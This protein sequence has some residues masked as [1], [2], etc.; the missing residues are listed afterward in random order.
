MA[1]L[2]NGTTIAGH[3]AIHAG[4]LA[5]HSIATTTYVNT[6]IANLVNSAPAAL[7]TLNE[8]AA[9][10][11][12]D[13]S[14]ATTIN[15]SLSTKL[16]NVTGNS[17]AYDLNISGQH[18]F[19]RFS[20]GQWLNAPV[21]GNYSHVLSVNGAGDNRTVQVYLGDVPGY[22]WWRPNQGGTWHPWER[23]LTSNNFN[24]WAP[25]L[26]G[27][28]ASGTWS[29]NVTGSA[30]SVAWTNVSSRPTALSQFTNDLGNYGG[31]LTSLPSHNHDD[32][33]Y[34]ES[35][36]DGRY[37]YYRGT[38]AE[39]DFQRFQDTAGEIRFDQINDF[40]NLSNRPGGYSYGGVLSMR[41]ANF[42]FQLW[43]SHTGDFYYKTQWSDDQYS[44][45]RQVITSLNIG[46][47]SVNFA[48]S[49]SQVYHYASRTDGTWYNAVWATGNPS[50]MYSADSVQIRSSDGA[51][52]AN[53]FYDNQ[54]TA[55]YVDPASSSRLYLL[56]LGGATPDAALSV[57]GTA[58]V[59]G[60]LYLGGTAGTVNSWGTRTTGASGYW[61]NAS[62]D[63][64]FNN[65]GYGSTWTFAVSSA[66][67][68]TLNR[69]IDANTTWGSAS[70]TTIFMGWY[71]GKIMLGNN[72]D[73]AHDWANAIGGNSIISTNKHH[74]YKGAYIKNN[75]DGA[76]VLAVDGVNGRLFT[77]TDSVL[78]TIY[79]VNTIA[80]LP[81]LEITADSTV[82]I[83]KYGHITTFS[84]DG[85]VTFQNEGIR[86]PYYNG[87][88]MWFRTNTHWASISGIDVIGGAGEFR[89]SSDSGSIDLRV[90]GSFITGAG[91]TSSQWDTAF[92]KRPTGVSFSGSS[93]KTLTLTLGDGSTLTAAFNDI[94]TD[95]NT[96]NQTLS[97][98]GSTLSIS[99]G[100]SVTIPSGGMSQAT[101]DSLYVRK[102][103]WEGN[104][105][106]GT[107][108]DIYGTIF[109]DSNS[110]AYYG[111]F[112]SNSRMNNL[113][114]GSVY[115][116]TYEGQLILGHTSYN[117][118]FLNGSWSSSVRAGIL[119]NCADEWEFAIHD[120]GTSVESAFIYAGGRLLMGRNI[121]WGTMYIEAAESFRAP[122]FYDSNDTTYYGD[123]ASTSWLRHLSVGDVNAANDGGWNARLNLTG[124]SHA[125]LDVKS[126]SDGIITTIYSHTGQG[127][128]RVGTWSNHPLAFM[129]NGG[130]AGYA[131]ANYLQG[132]DSVRAPIFYD[133]NNTGYYIDPD[134]RSNIWTLTANGKDHYFGTS[135]GWDGVGFGNLTNLHFQGHNQFWIGAG[136][137]YW[138][139]GGISTEHDLLITT[140]QGYDSTSYYRGITFGVDV[141]GNGS[142]GNYRLGRWQTYNTDWKTS[143]LQV[144][145]SLAVGYGARGTRAYDE[146]QYPRDRGVWAH[147]RGEAG[148]GAD[149]WRDHL[150]S[151]TAN[152]GGPW[153]S[154]ASLEVSSIY[155]GNSDIPALFRMH[156]W[157]SGAVEF[158][159]PQGRTLYIRESPGGSGSWFNTLE[160]Q[161]TLNVTGTTYSAG[162]RGNANVGGTGEAS[163]HPAGMYSGGTEWLY[164]TMYRNGSS[165]YYAGGWNYQLGGIQLNN[166]FEIQ[167]GGADYGRF[168]SWVHL[169]GHYGLYTGINGAHFYPN[170]SSYGSWKMEGSRNGWQGIEFAS[171][172]AGNVTLM[173]H[174]DSNRSGFHNN[175]YGWQI[176]WENGTLYVGKNSY[177]G[178]DATVFDT[179]NYTNWTWAKNAWNGNIY[180]HTD[181]RI[182]G[183]IF[184]DSND[185]GYYCDPNGNSRLAD[186]HANY[187][188]SYGNARVDS[189]LYL[190]QQYG[191][192]IVG[193]YASTRL[194]GVWAM[195][196]AYKIAMDGTNA[197]NLYGLAWS[198]PNAGGQ[199]GF[200]SNHGLIMMMYGTAF[201]TLSDTI[202]C[203]GDI[204][205]F[206]DARVKT[207]IQRI[208]DPIAKVMAIRG[209]TFTRTDVEDKE[210]RHAGVI[211]QEVLEVLPEVV[212][213]NKDN[214]HYSVAYGNL[215]ALLI[216]A[217]KEQQQQIE[218]LRAEVKKLRG[219]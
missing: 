115:T 80:G 23:I 67:A 219:E 35:E 197:G 120:S 167:Q 137:A 41:G 202:W 145:A 14:F 146:A 59:D 96:D 217:I 193:V 82:R 177:G 151:P 122:I 166:G 7:D 116:P 81:I 174:T 203:R 184:Y 209:V 148:Y 149:R 142:S 161:G 157:G 175:S 91:T 85:M 150:F 3:T 1:Q 42:G 5:A 95:T 118:N 98:S 181:G 55:Y 180:I 24:S 134:G 124:S 102:N 92:N 205:A 139:R 107:G 155:E 72:N 123:F 121:G 86:I 129:V 65:E 208:E 4:N 12:N 160:V 60:T 46:S 126:N 51:I 101:A 201:A 75:V 11:G 213:Q 57:S 171:G 119:A 34:T 84:N 45:W 125:R 140:M 9:A 190:D 108:G 77:V 100:N 138:Y 156:Q 27:T 52:R 172:S 61:R 152:G 183:T 99:G 192:T 135:S 113:I 170:N 37:L 127:V 131:Y 117:F 210:K 19:F 28:G 49:S 68:V 173:I 22:L 90:D 20:Q 103:T 8:L 154:F 39:N 26:T 18:A 76:E 29:I 79:S 38:N 17:G 74:F 165:T 194:Q 176:R 204:I 25:T 214:G 6:Q 44:G 196:D 97:I 128:G 93:T 132:V 163:W 94:D 40:N 162:Y 211:A 54:N 15:N 198:H 33:Y 195:G 187:M 185:S 200:L 144:D 13:A 104:S 47:Q 43:G 164:G 191:S 169:N 10:L 70:A 216:E 188:R 106:F 178:N 64:T 133:S 30:G 71:G 141:N 182:Y 66:G 153:G 31:F 206:S 83:G 88:H 105:Y 179:S 159:K 112:A 110:S 114:L 78:D 207:N 199:A 158:W 111:D 212:T 63:V 48:S 89:I 218:E 16:T 109:Y 53:I 73:G 2:I 130:I 21:S 136:N 143:R 50:H 36:S 56:G 69:H 215:S 62:R 168:S 189:N 186:I 58:H 147:G 32:R 87:G